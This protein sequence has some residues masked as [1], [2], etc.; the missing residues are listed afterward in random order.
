MLKK[1]LPWVVAVLAFG[2]CSDDTTS[3]PAVG[4]APSFR[5][6]DDRRDVVR[7]ERIGHPVWRPVDFHLFSA[8]LGTPD[9]GFAEFFTTILSLLPE[10]N[11]QF[12]P[13]LGVG[14]GTPHA[15]PYDGEL[16][17]GFAAQGFHEGRVF[18]AS[19][20]SGANGIYTAWMV[21][22]DPGTTGSSPD[23]ASGPIVPN[24]L[25]PMTLRGVMTRNGKVYDRDFA[26]FT[27]PPLDES[28]TPPF[29]VDGHSHF[30]VFI[31]EATVFGPAGVG[32]AG[33]YKYT[34]RMTD[35]E[36][37]GWIIHAHYAV[38]KKVVRVSTAL[39]RRSAE[40]ERRSS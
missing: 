28:L 37:N 23:F 39:G 18:G 32:P 14:P 26:N 8:P 33:N 13:Q 9:D 29:D 40:R 5:R 36:G 34:I 35:Q 20:F 22:P 19:E 38:K 7:L 3:G 21:V 25:F 10:P 6:E 27:V 24:T 17:R 1:H 30:P 15:P 12:H 31:G 16:R 2:A 11:H 4:L